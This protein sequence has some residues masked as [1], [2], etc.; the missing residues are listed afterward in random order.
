MNYTNI[1]DAG[2]RAIKSGAKQ[3]SLKRMSIVVPS[4]TSVSELEQPI[5]G[6]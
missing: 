1:L 4:D 5:L 3:M 6:G 2:L